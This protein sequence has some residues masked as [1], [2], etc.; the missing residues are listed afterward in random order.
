MYP[1]RFDG[2]GKFKGKYHIV[3]DPNVPPVIHAARRC[4]LPIKDDI[5]KELDDM[6]KLDV[7]TPVIKPTDWVSSL[8]YTQKPNGRWR[9]CLDPKDLNKAI[10]RTHHHTPTLEEITHQFAG[11]TVF[12]KVDAR[13]GY[14]SV[15]LDEESSF[16]TTFNSPGFGRY[17]FKRLPFGLCVS[18]DIFQ[19][20]MDQILEKCPG[21]IGIAD[22]I[23]VFGVTDDEHDRN[24]C[25]LMNVARDEG[26]VFN[27][28]KCEIK[29]NSIS[30]FGLIYDKDGARPNPKRI[31]AINAINAPQSPKELQEFLGIATYMA[32][33]IPQLSTLTATLRE[34]LKKDVIYEWT[35]SHQ[36]TFEEVKKMMAKEVT[37]AYFDVNKPSVLAID[38]S[39]KGVGAALTQEGR[40][41]A[42]AS[43]SLTE[44]EQRYA[45]IEREM[46][47]VVLACEKFHMYVY[48]K[49]FVVESDHKPLEMIHL[50]NLMS[51]PPR[52]QRMLL[53]LQ[54]YDVTI[55]YK[56]GKEMLLSDGLS[57]LNPL[58][59]QSFEKENVQINFVQFSDNKIETLKE[60][61][62]SDPELAALRDI[63]VD[64]W[65][66]KRHMV[67]KPIQPYWAFRDE[68]S[69]ENGLVLKG[70]R[71][72]IPTTQQ[73]NILEKIHEAHQGIT[74]C[75]LRAKSCVFW[76]NLNKDIEELIRQCPI[77]QEY[78]KSNPPEPLMPHE[79]PT[80]AWQ[81][82][83]TDLFYLN[84]DEYLIIA[85][86]YSKFQMVRP[87]P[88][89]RSNSGTIINIMKEIFSEQGVVD[90]VI[91]DNGSQ[92]SCR[93]F[94][95]F[96][97]EWNFKHITSSP[98]YAQSNGFI[99]RQVQTV[100]ATM[101]K[102]KQ[103][104][105]DLQ[106]ALLCLRTTPIDNHLPSPA[107][108]LYNRKIKA[109][110]PVK[111]TNTLPNKDNITER[112]QKMVS[113]GIYSLSAQHQFE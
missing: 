58:K 61:T 91:S 56:P 38:A 27:F 52:L 26:L 85:D 41:I 98:R 13:H 51:A 11:S 113:L 14:W 97:T 17:R 30:F 86:Y 20:R 69:I 24:L 80:R 36:I 75:Q 89:G 9:I 16:L 37:L 46:L 66:E 25:Q 40:V 104:N 102:A 5:K 112:L 93:Q 55:R 19:H 54:G 68:L 1:D 96:A 63:V 59:E 108:L 57:R 74:K 88:K 84:G 62:S 34:L 99:E 73:N 10:K 15:Q 105:G 31:E 79:I 111:I 81:I 28:D 33:F 95:Q 100:K 109:N 18:Q 70:G 42:F 44:T 101:K 29:K 103:S 72:V 4:P 71:I 67:P 2:I 7:I 110:L 43:K 78:Q 60:A 3:V 32:P 47:A 6:V 12:S 92:Y 106:K 39:L 107:E 48:G 50:K 87:I 49:P 21:T 77:C 90:T 22:D 65:P 53:R 94:K 45:N 35:S 83:G 23:A 76:K 8:A 64:G 82:I